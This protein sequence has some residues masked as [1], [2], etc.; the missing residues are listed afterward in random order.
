MISNERMCRSYYAMDRD[1]RNERVQV[2]Y[3]A[4]TKG[5]G[6]AISADNIIAVRHKLWSHQRALMLGAGHSNALRC[7]RE[8]WVFEAVYCRRR[9]KISRCSFFVSI[10]C[11]DSREKKICNLAFDWVDFQMATLSSRSTSARTACV[12]L[13]KLS[14]SSHR[15]VDS[16]HYDCLE[17]GKRRDIFIFNRFNWLSLLIIGYVLS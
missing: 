4:Y 5:V 9:W 12:R 16:I 2:A 3:D 14:E 6:E 17:L 11:A 7:G 10:F 1:K 13:L 8:R 15:S